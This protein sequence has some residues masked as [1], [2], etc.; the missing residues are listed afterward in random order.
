MEMGGDNATSASVF[1]HCGCTAAGSHG[2]DAGSLGDGQSKGVTL[3]GF[4]AGEFRGKRTEEDRREGA[5]AVGMEKYE[6]R[7]KRRQL[8][9]KQCGGGGRVKRGT[10]NW[11]QIS[12]CRSVPLELSL[13]ICIMYLIKQI[14]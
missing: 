11:V 14:L 13:P 12:V 3:E 9:D 5:V 2:R 10:K 8:A 4:W 7:K 6:Q 1:R